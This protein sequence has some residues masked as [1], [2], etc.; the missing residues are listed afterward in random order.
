MLQTS[1]S[2]QRTRNAMIYVTCWTRVKTTNYIYIYSDNGNQCTFKERLE[3]PGNFEKPR[4]A[5]RITS[6]DLSTSPPP[7]YRGEED[8]RE[9]ERYAVCHGKSDTSIHRVSIVRRLGT[10]ADLQEIIVYG[11]SG[12]TKTHLLDAEHQ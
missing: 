7:I 1:S 5:V 6:Q 12:L 10:R 9:T 11:T 4:E 8:T 3:L 2:V